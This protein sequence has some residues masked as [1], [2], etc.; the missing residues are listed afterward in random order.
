MRIP[1]KVVVAT[2]IS[3]AAASTAA[4]QTLELQQICPIGTDGV[5]RYSPTA[6]VMATL[7]AT[8]PSRR[9]IDLDGN[10]SEIEAERIRAIIL[11]PC[12]VGNRCQ[13]DSAK[14]V[15]AQSM[16]LGVFD[17]D[18]LTFSR[19]RGPANRSEIGAEDWL[20]A[21]AEDGA[22]GSIAELLDPRERFLTVTCKQPDR[23]ALPGTGLTTRGTTSTDD[24]E[25][26]APRE[27]PS[28]RVTSKL[29][30]L[31]REPEQDIKTIDAA[32]VS[33]ANSI[34]DR[35]LSFAIDGIVGVNVPIGADKALIPFVQYQ[36]ISVRDRSTTPATTKRN[37][38]KLGIGAVA[39]WRVARHDQIDFAPVYV[40]DYEKGSRVLS[41]KANWIPGFLRQID[42]LPV[43][44]ARPLLPNLLFWGL[45]P[46]ILLQGSHVFDAGTNA[47][48]LVASDYLRAGGDVT[49]DLWGDGALSNLTA[50]VAY[51]RLFRLTRGPRDVDLLKANVQYW[52]DDS[53][54]VSIGY[55]YERGLDEDTAD[56]VND[57]KLS[58]GIR[59]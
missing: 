12:S 24:A 57:W 22:A 28:V 51:K 30:E 40:V 46:R 4:A 54:H 32:T 59:F 5:R 2:C 7:D 26:P 48:L 29:E 42:E 10:G 20:E 39:S 15:A 33:V 56:R 44:R 11:N 19:R 58:L 35:K 6:L 13:E 53:Q 16:L 21:I 18:D 14:L 3:M 17:R 27:R 38:D 34:V 25:P 31:T 9:A 41:T 1:A 52:L 36:R 37:P 45:S 50:S 47:G 23:T 55:T 8:Q 49:L 43:M